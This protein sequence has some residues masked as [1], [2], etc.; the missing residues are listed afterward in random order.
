LLLLNATFA[1]FTV[2]I[3]VTMSLQWGIGDIVLISRL[4][5]QV[6]QT[7]K[8]APKELEVLEKQV[9]SIA[10]LL[11][12]IAVTFEALY[13]N[14][15]QRR[16]LRQLVTQCEEALK[17]VET[18]TKRYA[19]INSEKA[20]WKILR[21]HIESGNIQQ[22]RQQLMDQVALLSNFNSTIAM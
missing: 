8:Y 2:P 20:K 16:A 18:I 4:A 19:S 13:L 22:V 6:Y 12:Q 21:Y 7:F 15:S 14:R 17:E 11:D 9:L 5:W 10:N 3:L 1:P